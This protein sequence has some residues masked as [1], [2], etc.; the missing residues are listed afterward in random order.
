MAYIAKTAF[1]ARITNGR[2]ED[3]A[4]IAGRYQ[5]DSADA[6]CSAGMLCV[7]NGQ[8][9]CEGFANVKNENTWYMNAAA[10][11]VGAGDVI[12]ACNTHD[13][14]LLIDPIFG[15]QYAVGT[16]TLGLPAP[17]GRECTFTRID[18]DGESVYRFG[19][20]N[21]DGTVGSNT[22]FTIDDGLLSPAATAPQSGLY[23][24][25]RGTGKFIEGTTE[26]FGYL[27]L[28]AE[29]PIA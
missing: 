17:A 22:F 6:I 4:N 20:G 7:R 26:S 15:G 16:N 14:N 23:F 9:D 21:V 11:T 28:C 1:E 2:F 13:V 27:D 8:T 25:L 12:Y 29:K 5:E 3:L 24:S 19:E 18:F 10:S